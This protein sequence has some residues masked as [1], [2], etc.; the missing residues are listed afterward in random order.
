M[1]NKFFKGAHISEKKVKEI[2]SYFS[3]DL[4]A[5]QIAALT[6]L[7]R[8]TINAYLKYFRTKIA[9][10]IEGLDQFN[11]H[12]TD[13]KNGRYYGI[14]TESNKIYIHPLSEE[15]HCLINSP[16]ALEQDALLHPSTNSRL[17]HYHALIDIKQYKFTHLG[18]LNGKDSQSSKNELE[19]F[20]MGL[21]S[22][23]KKFRGLNSSTTHLH[24]RESE[25]RYNHRH[26]D[27]NP[28]LSE[29]LS[30]N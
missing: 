22:R 13:K 3:E 12:V 11:N 23:M 30:S 29:I 24:I 9:T 17:Q 10:G 7:S 18:I 25:F 1:K 15:E 8:I 21:R 2:I 26:V 28:I 20:W 5:T 4:T 16:V 14:T 6:G 19:E 27:I